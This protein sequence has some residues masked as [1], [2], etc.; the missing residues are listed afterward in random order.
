MPD[1]PSVC[2]VR[3]PA[4]L[5]PAESC[6]TSPIFAKCGEVLRTLGCMLCTGFSETEQRR[7]SSHQL[8]RVAQAWLQVANSSPVHTSA[9]HHHCFITRLY[10]RKPLTGCSYNPG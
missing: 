5:C 2:E 7:Y 4:V 3:Y 1:E 8:P 9:A 6:T 10:A